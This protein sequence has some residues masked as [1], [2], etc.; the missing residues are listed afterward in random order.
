MLTATPFV[1]RSTELDLLDGALAAAQAG[2]ATAVEVIGPA[3]IGKSRLLAELASRADARGA[4]ALTGA[5]AEYEQDLPFW[6]F[7]DALDEYVASLDPRVLDRLDPAVGAELAHVL[8]SVAGASDAEA[9]ALHERYRTHRAIRELLERLAAT[10]PLVLILDDFHWADP[11]STDLLVA[12]LHRPP[13]A[14]VVLVVAARPRQLPQRLATVLDRAHRAGTLQRAE[15]EALTREQARELVGGS[16]DALY[17]ESGGNP[18]YL[19]QLARAPAAKAGRE[20]TADLI[21][22]GVDVPPMVAAA[23]AEELSLLSDPAR[24]VLDAAAV[25]GDP[26]EVDLAAAAAAMSENEVLGALDE[27]TGLELVLAADAPR[28]FRFRHP[29]V[30]R[31]IYEGSPSGWRIAAHDRTARALAARGATAT[32]RA[33]HVER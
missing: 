17:E 25:A 13:A 33:H 27:L 26:F 5:A 6:V 30:R 21:G 8:P 12:L 14:G 7:V 9:P 4:V 23:L 29:I 1:G 28:R 10:R 24:R 31:A 11:A 2:T 18:F 22:G 20:V 32:T 15:L 3:G 16:A 19:E